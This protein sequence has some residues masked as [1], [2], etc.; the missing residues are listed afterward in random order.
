[1][2][3]TPVNPDV[4]VF[5]HDCESCRFLGHGRASILGDHKNGLDFYV[6]ESGSSDRS[7]IARY[8]DRGDQYLSGKLFECATLTPLD[9]VAL[10]NMLELNTDENER[11][12]RVLGEMWRST[13]KV[14]DYEKFSAG[15]LVFGEGNVIWNND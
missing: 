13:L 10:F 11:L 14:S 3:R 7:M 6:C 1:M 12:L 9:K 5:E 8:G 15:D 4:P 2:P